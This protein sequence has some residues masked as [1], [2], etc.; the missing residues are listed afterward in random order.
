VYDAD[1]EI[2]RFHD[3]VAAKGLWPSTKAPD[4][5]EELAPAC[6]EVEDAVD[7]GGA[8]VALETQQDLDWPGA[9][10]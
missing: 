4:E 3:D 10:S 8:A 9:G 7:A 2:G 6:V 5:A 1:E